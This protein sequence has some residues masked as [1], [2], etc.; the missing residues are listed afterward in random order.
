M[1]DGAYLF[2]PAFQHTKFATL[3]KVADFIHGR[4]SWSF[5]LIFF[6]SPSIYFVRSFSTRA[7]AVNE[8]D[9]NHV[10]RLD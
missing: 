1:W 3:V 2:Y 7:I 8:F 6:N 4:L 5:F 9:Q 10:L